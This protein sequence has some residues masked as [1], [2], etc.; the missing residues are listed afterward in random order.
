VITKDAPHLPVSAALSP[1]PLKCSH[2]RKWAPEKLKLFTKESIKL[3][4][5]TT[6][7]R[8]LTKLTTLK[9]KGNLHE[10]HH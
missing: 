9:R 6:L 4:N 5:A 10:Q 8:T 1:P 3:P 7:N 2:D